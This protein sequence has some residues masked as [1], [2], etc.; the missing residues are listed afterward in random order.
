M[1]RHRTTSFGPAWAALLG[2]VGLLVACGSGDGGG[3]AGGTTEGPGGTESSATTE[4]PQETTTTALPEPTMTVRI[5]NPTFNAFAVPELLA[6]NEGYFLQHG[7]AIEQVDI[8]RVGTVL[9]ALVS[10]SIDVAVFNLPNLA[11]AIEQGQ[12]VRMFCGVS[13]DTYSF[14]MAPA[15]TDLKDQ[16]ELGDWESVFQ[17]LEGGALGVPALGT[18][19]EAYM[20]ASLE[21]AGVDPATVNFV[22]V[23]IGATAVAA[24]ET[25]QVDAAFVIPFS[26]VQLLTLGSA[27][28]LMSL[29]GPDA[30]P[31][32]AHQVHGYGATTTWIDEHPDEARAL[33]AGIE[34]GIAT[35]LDPDAAAVDELL[36]ANGITGD[37]I[38][39]A[40][41]D[42]VNMTYTSEIDI[43][44]VELGLQLFHDLGQV[45][46]V[47]DLDEVVQL[48]AD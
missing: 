15:D 43:D 14:L 7:L 29:S 16:D 23:G 38:A 47:L 24:I 42:L 32:F 31:P 5:A 27:V 10:G 25:G 18:G 1:R 30:P 33:C 34:D 41:D 4:A 39:I 17:Q 3:S 48:P 8:T 20:R 46:R 45:T 22:A 21:Q 19:I 35:A 36:T 12:P 37:G 40:R 2:A 26:D 11:V 28:S 13:T 9:P 6:L 44:E